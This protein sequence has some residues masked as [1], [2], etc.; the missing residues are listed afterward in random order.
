[1][2]N[3]ITVDKEITNRIDRKFYRSNYYRSVAEISEL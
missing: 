1:M 2:F 3:H